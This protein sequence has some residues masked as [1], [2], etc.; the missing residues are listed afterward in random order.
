MA[1][2]ESFEFTV[3]VK[4]PEGTKRNKVKTLVSQA[5]RRGLEGV[6]DAGGSDADVTLVEQLKVTVA[7]PLGTVTGGSAAP[8]G[9]ATKT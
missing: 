6:S 9:A 7:D 5:V 4:A 3:K 1:K 8:Q 2:Q